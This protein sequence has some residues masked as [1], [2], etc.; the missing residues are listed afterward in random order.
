MITSDAKEARAPAPSVRFRE[1]QR[2]L[3]ADLSDG[4]AHLVDHRRRHRLAHHDWGI[5]EGLELLPNGPIKT[6]VEGLVV[7][8]GLAIDG[9]GRVLRASS[10]LYIPADSLLLSIIGWMNPPHNS[11]FSVLDVWLVY[12]QEPDSPLPLGRSDC[13]PGKN[14]RWR[15]SVNIVVTPAPGNDVDP[16]R[17]PG[18]PPEDLDFSAHDEWQGLTQ[19]SWPVYLGRVKLDLSTP[20]SGRIKIDSISGTNRP[21]ITLVGEAVVDP[22]GRAEV[23]LGAGS[24]GDTRRFAVRVAGEDEEGDPEGNGDE[25]GPTASPLVER[26]S[27]DSQ[28]RTTIRGHA[29]QSSDVTTGEVQLTLDLPAG[30]QP[31]E[32]AI[33]FK[34]LE[35]TPEAAKPWQAYRTAVTPEDGPEQDVLRFE[36]EHPGKKGDP[37]AKALS[38]GSWDTSSTSFMPCLSVTADC[39]VTVKGPMTVN[40]KVLRGPV[41]ANPDDPRFVAALTA[42]LAQ[43]ATEIDIVASVFSRAG[44]NFN[45]D[46]VIHL[47]ASSALVV[48]DI[49]VYY[50][51]LENGALISYAEY[52]DGKGLVLAPGDQHSVQ[53][54][55]IDIGTN[56]PIEFVLV[57]TAYD[58]NGRMVW[59]SDYLP[60]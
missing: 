37:R 20:V 3:A 53:N 12:G 47:A 52:F 50:Y 28:G 44:P 33:R 9:Y 13:G 48:E 14:S 26:L 38:I 10:S 7:Q 39:R 41:E 34:S 42:G 18:V 25:D 45:F 51:V 16:C 36:I 29:I 22:G 54:L 19:P 23:R 1:G 59:G 11:I 55:T 17:P 8:S 32:T 5:V 24:A 49:R 46:A 43:G 15:E 56:Q 21:Y 6:D 4:Q 40:G 35:A 30:S 27:I 31:P 60:A 58:P 2:L 57:V